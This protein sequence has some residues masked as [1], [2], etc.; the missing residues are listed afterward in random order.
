MNVEITPDAQLDMTGTMEYYAK[1]S[2]LE[3]AADFYFEVL[4]AI[5]SL[6][7]RPYSYPLHVGNYRRIN[8]NR[9]PYNILFRTIDDQTIR[10]LTVR[11]D[12]RRPS[13]GT[14]RN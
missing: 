10:I 6:A 8:L 9:F 5:D 12:S 13:Y 11:H 14:E 3:L 4:S 2:G 1:Q 7:L